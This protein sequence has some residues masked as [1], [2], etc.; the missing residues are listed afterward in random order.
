LNVLQHRA[1][2]AMAK[3]TSARTPQEKH[4]ARQEGFAVKADLEKWLG[5]DQALKAFK[6]ARPKSVVGMYKGAPRFIFMVPAGGK[7]QT[8]AVTLPDGSKIIPIQNQIPVPENMVDAMIARGWVRMNSV[9][10]DLS[11]ALGM[12]DP[13]R[14]N[15]S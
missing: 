1:N 4:D 11:S 5:D 10:T 8:A 15:N 14:P 6:S 7:T 12:S 9:L 2:E 13:A 3:I